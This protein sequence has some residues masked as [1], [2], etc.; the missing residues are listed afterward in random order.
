V[1]SSENATVLG[2]VFENNDQIG[3][4]GMKTRN[5]FIKRIRGQNYSMSTG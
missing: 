5:P 3:S 1:I 4:L 2:L